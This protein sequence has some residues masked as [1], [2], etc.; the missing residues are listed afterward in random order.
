M[1]STFSR[2]KGKKKKR[3]HLYSIS[4][5][6]IQYDTILSLL[7]IPSQVFTCPSVLSWQDDD[8]ID[9]ADDFLTGLISFIH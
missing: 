9:W 1:K 3:N 5:V 6:Q 4:L 2:T 8:S 7:S